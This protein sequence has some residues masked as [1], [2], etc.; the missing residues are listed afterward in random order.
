VELHVCECRCK[1]KLCL[2]CN[3]Q[4]YFLTGRIL[5]YRSYTWSNA[6]YLKWYVSLWWK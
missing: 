5:C 6:D 1:P 3:N 4:R 2:K